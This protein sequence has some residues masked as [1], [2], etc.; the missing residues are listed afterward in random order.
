MRYL[1]ERMKQ[2]TFGKKYLTDGA[3]I[4]FLKRGKHFLGRV[5]RK[6]RS[7]LPQ[8]QH[9]E[10]LLPLFQEYLWEKEEDIREVSQEVDVIVPIYNGYE[11]L[12][13]LFQDLPKAGMM[14]RFI[15]VDDKS[16]D[17]RV[18]ELEQEFADSHPGTV[19]LKNPQNYGFVK[20]VNQGL[21]VSK[22]H[23]AL[24]NTDTEL[25]KDWLK[26]LM[27]P[28]LA[29]EMVAS[30]TPYTNS[31]TIFSFP[32]F[33][34]NNPIYRG[35]DVDTLDSY[36]RKVKPRYALA[37]TGVGFCMGMN[38]KAIDEIGILDYETFDRGFG[39]ENEW[40]QRAIKKGYRNVQV[41]NLFIYHK[42]GGSFQSEEK[43]R[44][45]EDHMDRLIKKFPNY[46]Y[47]VSAFIRKDPNKKVRQL[48]E[49]MIDTHETHSV[50]Y[51]DHSLGGGATSYLNTKKEGFLQDSG[52][53]CVVRYQIEG[54]N[55]RFLFENDRGRQEY[56]F[57][58][59]PELLEIGKWLHFDEIYI[60]E[61][62]TYPG[63]WEAQKCILDLGAQQEAKVIMLFHD[64]FALCP[65]I[66]LM[67]DT[68][69]YCGMPKEEECETCYLKKGF[70]GQYGC[71]SRKEWIEHWK[72]FLSGCTEVRTFSEDT[73]KRVIDAYGEGLP[74]TMVG[75]QVNY[76]F[77][78]RK[79]SKTTDTLNIGLLG[80]LAVHKGS[81]FIK[82]LLSEIERTGSNV[83]IILIGRTDGVNLGRYRNFEETG[84]YELSE[85]PK[86]IYE[87]D[88]DL[89]LISSVWPETFSYTAE[90]IIKMGMP[91]AAFDL[92][93]PAE[94]VKRYEKG[95]I[96]EKRE[97]AD[98]LEEIQRF[99]AEDLNLMQNRKRLK[100]VVYVVEYVSFSSRYRI[101]HMQEELLY[102][103]VL[104][105]IWETK[106]LPQEISWEEI[107][108]MVIYRC[109]YREP[110]KSLMDEAQGHGVPLLYDI[111]DYIF[112]YERIK[113][114]P[115]MRDKEY[116]DFETYSRLIRTCMEKCGGLIVSTDHLKQGAQQ[117]FPEK[118]IFVNRNVASAQMLI[119]SALAQHRRRRMKERLVLGYFSGSNT[120]G[121]DFEMISDVLLEFMKDHSEVY[122]K[123]VGCL[124]LP[125][126]F[127]QVEDR[128]IPVG[129]MDWRDLPDVIASV[130][131]N[132][133]P[134]EDSF[135]H[136][137]KS[138]NKWM[139]AALVKVPTIGSYNEEIARAT[140]PEEN[141]LLC[142]TKEEWRD[143]LERFR[144]RGVREEVAARAFDYVIEHKTTLIKNRA[145][146]DFVMEETCER[147]DQTGRG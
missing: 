18:H 50:L 134:L 79:E 30:S 54:N 105:E 100:K 4:S 146:L 66:N 99:A 57:D 13:N 25:P 72:E 114:L 123:V 76:A 5:K 16:P 36:F 126:S 56:E 73:R 80:V 38:R 22:N 49:M 83:R 104:G 52:C 92:G 42:H 46:N 32:N 132:L 143:G 62:V 98:V 26:R 60:N 127:G 107:G 58:A 136:A 119:L 24:V 133:M 110:L 144:D 118:R 93:A 94:R 19:V 55:Y 117:S 130:D 53:V 31:A 91:I 21:S 112:E 67:D 45:I 41:E 120:H 74:V 131:I 77:P 138:E 64:Y 85:L 11:Y 122:L 111:D 90:E 82:E 84:G 29:D 7:K 140:A 115:F 86:L 75:H 145:L 89:F 141:I 96:L 39:E 113:S 128:I 34:Y 9:Y 12:K 1:F 78:I 121:R 65:T 137:C 3:L 135:F 139:E 2:T 69:K 124:K 6:L 47:Q 70:A 108:A 95:L 101:E 10:K 142:R 33:C 61:L 40:C 103:G 87:H 68:Q 51:F 71:K 116:R 81:G 106:T 129:F 147:M 59:L 23:V 63:L 102:Q 28:I 48:M 88:I 17:E 97:A 109:R 20:S 125:E 27:A 35:K 15:L 8:S 37:P 14:C 44:L 43:K